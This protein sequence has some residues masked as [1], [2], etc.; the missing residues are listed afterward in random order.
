MCDTE[1]PQLRVVEVTGA[2]AGH[3]VACHWAEQIAAGEIQ[4]HEVDP[5]L[6]SEGFGGLD[7]DTNPPPEAYLGV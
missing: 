2:T 4:P 6:V 1:R 7:V 3:R 5:T